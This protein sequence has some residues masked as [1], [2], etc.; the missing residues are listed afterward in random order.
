MK[1]RHP[2]EMWLGVVQTAMQ[3]EGEGPRLPRLPCGSWT[4]SHRDKNREAW[5]TSMVAIG[6]DVGEGWGTWAAGTSLSLGGGH[7][8]KE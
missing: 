5:G 8:E 1:V 6:A 3:P 2:Q 7:G 4:E